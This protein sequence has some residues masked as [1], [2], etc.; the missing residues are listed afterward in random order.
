[1]SVTKINERVIA[2]LHSQKGE[3]ISCDDDVYFS[4]PL[5]LLI[6]LRLPYNERSGKNQRTF[7]IDSLSITIRDSSSRIIDYTLT[8]LKLRSKF[9]DSCK[10][11]YTIHNGKNDNLKEAIIQFNEYL[12][13]PKFYEFSNPFLLQILTNNESSIN[14][15]TI[16]QQLSN[17]FIYKKKYRN[18]SR[19]H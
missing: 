7:L 3:F 13:D 12:G 15:I 9:A 2:T 11:D 16:E 6:D 1:M 10:Y 4:F 14:S 18:S 5:F 8:S 19:S 17:G